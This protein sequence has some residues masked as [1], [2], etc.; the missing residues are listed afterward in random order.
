MNQFVIL[1]GGNMGDRLGYLAEAKQRITQSCGSIAQ[2]SRVYESEAW[3]FESEHNFLNQA[4]VL[5]SQF[6]AFQLLQHLQAIEKSLGRQS[7]GGGYQSRTLDLDILFFG[8]HIIEKEEL[9]IPH[10][11]IATRKFTL[12]CVDELI[13]NFIHP[14][15]QISIHQ[16]LHDCNDPSKVWIYE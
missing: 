9:I 7:K 14:V 5:Q 2:E 1:L 16:L 4:I 15:L 10:P 8:N 6:D 12:L 11:R 3:G 13:P